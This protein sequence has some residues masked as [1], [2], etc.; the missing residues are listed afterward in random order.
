MMESQEGVL[1][2][3]GKNQVYDKQLQKQL[4]EKQATN[5]WLQNIVS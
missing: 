4:D 1:E 2:S 3:D 5:D